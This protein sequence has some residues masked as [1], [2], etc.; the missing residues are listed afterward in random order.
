MSYP[1]LLQAVATVVGGTFV[2]TNPDGS[3]W[4]SG[5][6][7]GDATGVSG[8]AGA[9]WPPPEI[10]QDT[11]VA[12]V[13][14]GN[15]KLLMAHPMSGRKDLQD[16]VH[17]RV[18]VGHT[19]LPTMLSTVAAFHDTVPTAFDSHMQLLGTSTVLTASCDGPQFLEVEWGGSAYAALEFVIGV[20]RSIP[21]T[22]VG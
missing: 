1:G 11:P 7:S 9:F 14:P 10:V 16:Q 17:V 21:V 3:G 8:L 2:R 4:Y 20:E 6:D 19:S 5:K 13:I 12:L 22:Y 15:S 18:L